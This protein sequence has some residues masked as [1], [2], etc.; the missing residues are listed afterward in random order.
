MD[1]VLR[2]PPLDGPP[3][4]AVTA[5]DL[6]IGDGLLEAVWLSLFT[7]ARAPAT[8]AIEGPD[9]RGWWGDALAPRPLGSL[10]WTLARE[11]QT[12]ETRLRARDYAAEALAWMV[13]SDEPAVAG[14]TAVAVAAWWTRPGL[15]GLRVTLTLADGAT[16]VSA[17]ERGLA[18]GT[19]R[20]LEMI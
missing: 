3:D 9:R 13:G 12:E 1:L 6:I 19:A 5:G 18:D 16:G 8:L 14:V 10:L 11:K 20:R 4:L 17:F 15:L 7:D 2:F